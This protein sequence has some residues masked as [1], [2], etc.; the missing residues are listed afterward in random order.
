MKSQ[1]SILEHRQWASELSRAEDVFLTV[2]LVSDACVE[3][4]TV[5]KSLT[6]LCPSPFIGRH[7]KINALWL[8]DDSICIRLMESVGWAKASVLIINVFKDVI[9]VH[10]SLKSSEDLRTI[11]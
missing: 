8:Q 11:K 3:N 4:V 5:L 7:A 10:T 2:F 1:R 9:L 6:C